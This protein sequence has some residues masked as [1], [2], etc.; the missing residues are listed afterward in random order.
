MTEGVVRERE[1]KVGMRKQVAAG[2]SETS[3]SPTG[4]SKNSNEKHSL[5]DP[6]SIDLLI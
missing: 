2:T 1:K 6:R 3:A 4:W 5:V